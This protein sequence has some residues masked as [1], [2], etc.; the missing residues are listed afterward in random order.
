MKILQNDIIYGAAVVAI[1]NSGNA[2]TPGHLLRRADQDQ[3]LLRRLP[4]RRS[5][6]PGHR[7][8]RLL[9]AGPGRDVARGAVGGACGGARARSRSSSPAARGGDGARDAR[10]AAG[11]RGAGRGLGVARPRRARRRSRPTRA[12]PRPRSSAGASRPP[13]RFAFEL[14]FGPYLPDVDSEFDGTRHPYQDYFGVGSH[15]LTQIEFDSRSSTASAR[16]RVGAG[17]GYFSVSGTVAR[18]PAAPACRAATS[19]R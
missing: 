13:Q 16:S 17:L 10:D 4:Q 18:S 19:R 1:D 9:H 8:R 7:D 15:L 14:R 5:R 2:S 6:P 12:T 3:E 11:A